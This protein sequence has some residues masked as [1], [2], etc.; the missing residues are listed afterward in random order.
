M[1]LESQVKVFYSFNFPEDKVK[2]YQA[3]GIL[4]VL[5]GEASEEKLDRELR[6]MVMEKWEFRVR[7][8]DLQEYLVVFPDKGSLEPFTR[9]SCFHM[10]I[11]GLKGSIVKTERSPETSSILHTVW[12]K[13]HNIPD[14][15]KEAEAVKE[16]ITPVAEPLIVDELSLIKSSLVRA[17]CRCR[18]PSAINGSIEFFFNEKRYFHQI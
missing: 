5:E 14:L 7:K 1:V 9:L 4:T 17:Q 8:I 13:I 16:I 10:S 15:A 11:Y 2:T 18:N 12:I 3:T 6:N